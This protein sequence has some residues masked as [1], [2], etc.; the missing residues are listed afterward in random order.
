M[1]RLR[2]QILTL[3]VVTALMLIIVA[4][5]GGGTGTPGTPDNGS[6]SNNQQSP[7]TGSGPAGTI[8]LAHQ[9]WTGDW[10]SVPVNQLLLEELGYQV[11]VHHLSIPAIYASL[12]RGD[13]DAFPTAWPSN[14]QALLDE[15]DNV[16]IIGW[17]WTDGVQGWGVPTWFAEEYNIYYVSDLADPEIAKLLDRDGDG[18]GD[19]LGCESGWVCETT[20]DAILK[21]MGLDKLYTQVKATEA[22]INQAIDDAM[23]NN[24]PVLF[25]KFTPDWIFSLYPYPEKI[26]WLKNPGYEY[27]LDPNTETNELGWPTATQATLIHK[28]LKDRHP[29]AASLL[30]QVE[31]PLDDYND[32][33][34]MQ[35]VEGKTSEEEIYEAARQWIEA[36]RDKVDQWLATARELD[37]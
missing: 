1:R 36:N 25:F 13:L 23:K 29:A 18:T 21:D 22:V 12:D 5:G 3:A 32:S 31:I 2:L 27:P 20:N 17:D 9:N 33:I 16:E 4:C 14:Q 8:K 35:V 7:S 24:E 26:T 10:L 11:E 28:D 6:G 15:H 34:Y 19:L 37:L 30:S